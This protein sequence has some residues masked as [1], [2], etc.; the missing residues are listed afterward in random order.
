MKS[1]SLAVALVAL[2]SCAFAQDEGGASL[3]IRFADGT[4]RFHVGEMISLELSF[5][6]SIPD[7]YSM[8]MRNYD[9][10]GRL[11]IEQ[12]HVTPRGRDPLERYYS[13]GG[14]VGGGLGGSRA[15]SSEP[16]I[17]REDLN[18]WVVLDKPGHYCL[19][20][21]SG[22]V[23]RRT[24][25]NDE[26]VEL[27][28][29]TLEFDVID[30]DAAWKHQTFGTAVTTLNIGTSTDAEKTAALRV[31]RF[32]DTPE[33]IHELVSHLGTGGEHSGWD[34]V[35]GLA[36]SRDQNLVVQELEQ[37]MN[38]PDVALTSDYFYI[39]AKL[40]TQLERGHMPPYPQKD[41]EQQRIWV[42]QMQAY[43]KDIS[44]LQDRL[45]E[46]AGAL[47]ATKTEA[48]KTQTIRTILTRPSSERDGIKPL[49]GL[50]PEEVAAAF[51]NLS[52]D[53]QWEML[54]DFWDRFKDAA[55]G[56]PLKKIALQP[57][58]SH[59]MLREQALWC[60]YD[61]DPAE[62]TPIFLEEMKHP[63]LDNGGSTVKGETL[64]LLP[65][66]TLPQFDEML[67]A[68]IEDK[69]S[70]T[71]GLDAQL[72]GR[73]STSAILPRVK[74]V[75]ETRAG[76]WD[77]VSEDGFV[78]YFLRVDSDYGVSRL[79]QAPSFCMT[80]SLRAVIKIH[81]W[82]EVEPA[83]IA[84][85]NDPTL[86]RARQAAETLAKYGSPQ[87]EKALWERMRK[88]HEQWSERGNELV[89]R[90]RMLRDANE[91]VS[92]QYGLVQSI[93]S[94]QAW[95]LTDDE[96]TD[97]ENLTLGQERDNVKSW[98]WT[99]E[100]R[101]SIGFVGNTFLGRANQYVATDLPS[102]KA[103]LA[104]YPSGTKVSLSVL[105]SPE[106][107][108]LLRAAILGVARERGL[109]VIPTEPTN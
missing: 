75:Y 36:S 45:Y 54:T 78:L 20:V 46:R 76:R 38:A 57:N 69:Q 98:H 85:L 28:S 64:G 71:T 13:V 42:Q 103:K 12:F 26:P 15:L 101:L 83:I 63:H 44:D 68:R 108:E 94:A 87:A 16:R 66:A 93:G 6:A 40:K 37:Q 30:A 53:Q 73:Y 34:E 7:T 56:A 105:G 2:G 4:T 82:H 25:N 29:N 90:S 92:F 50:P 17:I 47:V 86:Y 22:R 33:S 65:N 23:A 3:T 95:L 89:M 88:F 109:D 79:T 5:Q 10:S 35:A 9:R 51:L 14:F 41:A 39:L 102:L 77:C 84:E 52:A 61:L 106:R 107:E 1:L 27:R 31:L 43:E 80:N 96:I 91:A 97:L 100:V 70:R 48:A 74:S 104:Q 21:T 58:I 24:S 67:A 18:E 8:E 81:R 32:L 59:Q 60:L 99:S 11:D 72:I 62:A 49:A 55:M 19:Y